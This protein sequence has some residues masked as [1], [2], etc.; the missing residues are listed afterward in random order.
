[1]ALIHCP[2]CGRQVSDQ[3]P[4]CPHCGRPIAT[5]A[6]PAPTQASAPTPHPERSGC[7]I[8]WLS[9]VVGVLVAI[10]AVFY[11]TCP[12]EA[13]HRAEVQKVGEK[14]IRSLAAKQDSEVV[15]GLS[16]LFGDKVVA[17]AV[18]NLLEVD[19]YGVVSIGR[20]TNPQHPDKSTLISVGVLGHVFTASADVLVE[21]IE[22]KIEEQKTEVTRKIEREITEGINSAVEE[23]KQGVKEQVNDLTEDV[24][25]DLSSSIDE[26]LSGHNGLSNDE[27]E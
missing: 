20:I 16:L 1:M 2:D 19:N 24:E 17:M 27:E 12:D 21:R 7:G 23:V 18:D 25:K 11:F 26:F 15:T 22:S 5:Y 4:R 13:D 8:G 9:V 14:A 3:A 6:S 10:A